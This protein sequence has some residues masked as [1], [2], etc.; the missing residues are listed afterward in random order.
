MK[1]SLHILSTAQLS[2]PLLL[3]AM[4]KGAE[5]DIQSF[6]QVIDIADEP[7]VLNDLIESFQQEKRVIFTSANAVYSVCETPFFRKPQWDIY[8]TAP[9]TKKAILEYFDEATIHATAENA[10]SLAEAIVKEDNKG[11][12]LFFCGD[13]RMDVLPELL[14][15]AGI[16]LKEL[17]VYKTVETP[18]FI[19]KDYDAILFFS[20]SGVNSYFNLNIPHE[21]TLLVAIGETTA[22]ALRQNTNNK[23][24]I[25]SKPS[26][27]T[28][29]EETLIQ[30]GIRN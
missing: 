3:R 14:T 18:V 25:A 7:T 27:E 19:E 9:A 24:L 29:V 11:E 2:A 23:M 12:M 26:K 17:V 5:I 1:R 4:E 6:I 10:A 30:L 22:A 16:K 8:C 15:S 28:M 21:A 20:P 13:A